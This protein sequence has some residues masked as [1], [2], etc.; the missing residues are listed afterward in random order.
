LGKYAHSIDYICRKENTMNLRIIPLTIIAVLYTTHLCASEHEFSFRHLN[1]DNSSLSHNFT[2]SVVKD[3]LGF[4]W[5]GTTNGL[6]RFDGQN[7]SVLYKGDR[8]LPSSIILDLCLDNQKRMVVRT[9]EGACRYDYSTDCFVDSDEHIFIEKDSLLNFRQGYIK[10]MKLMTELSDIFIRNVTVDKVGR[11]W[12]ASNTG[13]YICN[14]KTGEIIRLSHTPEDP[15]SLSDSRVS[16]VFHTEN[17]EVWV[18]TDSGV[19]Y[20]DS[21]CNKFHKHTHFNGVSLQNSNINGFAYDNKGLLYI[22]TENA[23]IFTYDIATEQIGEFH[24]PALPEIILGLNFID[25]NLWIKLQ[26]GILQIDLKS[27]KTRRFLRD[28]EGQDL[29]QCRHIYKGKRCGRTYL[30][31]KS[32]LYIF[33]TDEEEFSPINDFKG[34]FI[35]NIFEDSNGLLWVSTYSDG[36]LTYNQKSQK[37]VNIYASSLPCNR[38]LEVYEDSNSD[39]WLCTFGSGICRL[40]K[41]DGTFT[42]FSSKTLGNSAMNDMTYSIC[43]DSHG[44]FWVNTYK[45]LL[46]FNPDTHHS[47][48]YTTAQG[49]LDNEF[50]KFTSFILPDDRIF[51]GSQNGMVVFNAQELMSGLKSPKILVTDFFIGNER[52]DAGIRNEINLKHH[53][54][55]FGFGF[56]TINS[57]YTG[58]NLECRLEGY[59]DLWQKVNYDNTITF[60]NVPHGE[61]RLQIR[62]NGNSEQVATHNDIKILIS[63]PWYMSLT[64]KISYILLGIGLLVSILFIITVII[65][66]REKRLMAVRQR[67]EEM[68]LLEER[69]QFLSNVV[70]E[71]KDPLKQ[72][73]S[74]LK[75]AVVHSND[76][77][78]RSDLEIIDKTTSYLTSLA[79]D[80]LEKRN[81]IQQIMHESRS[82]C[83]DE[84]LS[85]SKQDKEFL[86]KMNE[87]IQ[88]N[89][90]DPAFAVERLEEAA[91]MSS[92]TLLRKFKKLLNT[93]PNNYIRTKRLIFAAKLMEDGNDRVSDIC[94]SCGFNSTSYFTKCFKDYYGMTPQEYLQ[95]IWNKFPVK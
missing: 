13:I 38:I 69:V 44:H 5:I 90:A 54:N 52:I 95:K 91:S 64:A 7:I 53:Q 80:L 57:H 76:S 59:S 50:V 21:F 31:T 65:E 63:P 15:F 68:E 74:P 34:M 28:A 86:K 35:E 71:I 3:T 72:I 73:K 83:D 10:N 39:I 49:L 43:E 18:T 84:D 51:L 37:I 77:S 92:S 22:S 14:S 36:V 47:V 24:H 33:I 23:G 70:Q 32:G 11:Y 48:C 16:S 1:M 2:T 60:V 6:N 12:I 17:G 55:T 87:V 67:E 46:R 26:R 42:V 20:T 93:T 62:E 79:N 94:W 89:I 61:Y 58:N 29:T 25:D 40:N 82:L 30:G 88:D 56:A 45:G 85:I 41:E 81:L 27:S 78:I 8:K 19:S 75:D 4:V 9:P 66:K